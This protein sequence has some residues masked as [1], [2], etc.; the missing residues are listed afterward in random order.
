MAVIVLDIPTIAGESR[1]ANYRDKLDAVSI[2]DIID[3]PVPQ[4]GSGSASRTVGKS[5]HANIEIVRFKDRG[6]PLLANA[7]ATGTNLGTVN[8][9]LFR[10]LETG[11]VPYLNYKLEDTFLSRLEHETE[12]DL[13]TVYE[14]H[15]ADGGNNLVGV[16]ARQGAASLLP[17]TGSEGVASRPSVRSVAPRMG[18]RSTSVECERLWLNP[19]SVTWTYTEYVN[20]SS[21]GNTSRG[22]NIQEGV[23]L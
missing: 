14:A 9:Y 17:V 19:A 3:V 11:L 16:S 1:V 12:D 18:T 20:G 21:A 8:I 15:I 6:S 22:W 4:G 23:T 5:R 7:C 2:G 10:T 13:G